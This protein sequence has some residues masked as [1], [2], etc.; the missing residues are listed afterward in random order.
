MLDFKQ[1]NVCISSTIVLLVTEYDHE[2]KKVVAML[3][4]NT[5]SG[6]AVVFGLGQVEQNFTLSLHI[7]SCLYVVPVLANMQRNAMWHLVVSR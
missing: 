3:L 4:L 5:G 6:T 7:I 1:R 2:Q